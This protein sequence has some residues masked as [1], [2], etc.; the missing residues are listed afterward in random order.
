M[1]SSRFA[2]VQTGG[3]QY[4]VKQGDRIVVERLSDEPQKQ[5][6]LATLA[7]FDTQKSEIELGYPHLAKQV[8]ATVLAHDKGE[9]T[10]IAKFKSKVRYRRVRGFRPSLTQLEI[11]TI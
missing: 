1:S 2:I 3:K 7:I 5:V 8:V 9:K 11:G 4:V 6:K 10:R